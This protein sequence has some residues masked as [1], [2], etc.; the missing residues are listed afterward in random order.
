MNLNK[1]FAEIWK[2]HKKYSFICY[3]VWI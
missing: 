2:S 3:G 1:I